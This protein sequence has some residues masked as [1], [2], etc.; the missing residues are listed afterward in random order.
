MN[1]VRC[2]ALLTFIALLCGCDR[3][4]HNTNLV[5]ETAIE[6]PAPR[7]TGELSLEAAIHARRSIREYRDEPLSLIE[8]GQLLWAAQ[9]ITHPA[10]LRTAPS[11]GALYPLEIYLLAGNVTDL[12]AGIYY[13]RPQD[14][15]LTLIQSG[16]H[17]EALY[18]AALSQ[19]AVRQAAAVLVITAIFER[20][21]G[22]YGERGQ[23][24]VHIEVGCAAQNVYLQ[25][26]ALNL[27]TVFIGA[28]YDNQVKRLLFLSES[29]VPL[30]IMPFGKIATQ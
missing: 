21:T 24:Y 25:A 5:P 12:P 4:V 29:R 27:G 20:T 15:T 13:Y 11:A 1:R 7:T 18:Q 16:D 19:S 30:G 26:T 17:R 22:K 8:V 23:Q 14:H 2:L 9:G 3:A 10:G 28:F 6:L